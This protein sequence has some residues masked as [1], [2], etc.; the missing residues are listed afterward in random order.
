MVPN[1]NINK[2]NLHA[3]VMVFT[4]FTIYDTGDEQRE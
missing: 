3:H 2:E 1:I 4:V